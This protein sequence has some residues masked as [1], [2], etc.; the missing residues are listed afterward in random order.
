[1][2]DASGISVVVTV[3][4][5]RAALAEL[6]DAL[7]L[8]TRPPDEVVVVDAGSTDGTRELLE[9]RIET[10]PLRVLSEPGANISAGRNAG[11]RAA[12]HG[13]I[14]LTDAG[15]RPDPRWLEAIDAARAHADFVAGVYRVEGENDFERA[16]ADALYPAPEEL[17]RSSRALRAWQ[18]FFG[19]RFDAAAA[20]GRSMAFTRTVWE[21]AGG[22]PEELYAGEDVAFSRAAARSAAATRL[23]AGAVVAWRPRATWAANARMYRTYARGDVRRGSVVTYAIRAAAWLAAVT[24]VLFGG[25][26]GRLLVVGWLA[27]YASL[28]FV[29]ARARQHGPAVTWRIPLVI[30]MKDLSQ[31]V[32]ATLGLLDGARGVPQPVP[33]RRG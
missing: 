9:E 28:P 14:A 3:F 30:A 24:L 18:R 5:D 31:T 15:C 6:L 20:T 32:G 25:R 16:L 27:A 11:I 4:D 23:E 2:S 12:S 10:M 29:R 17:G 22:F 7:A 26:A 33:K 21:R 19:K 1:M 8:Q 13:W